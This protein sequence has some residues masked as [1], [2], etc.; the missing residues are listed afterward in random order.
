[1]PGQIQASTDMTERSIRPT[2]IR[3][4]LLEAL[5]ILALWF[6]GHHFAG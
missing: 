6:V 1:M 5:V 3:V 4:I 2:A